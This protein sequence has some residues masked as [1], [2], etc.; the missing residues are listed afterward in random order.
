MHPGLWRAHIL[1]VNP[2]LVQAQAAASQ[3]PHGP[4]IDLPLNQYAAWG[5][6]A[7]WRV[8]LLLSNGTM[9]A[10]GGDQLAFLELHRGNLRVSL[11]EA[12][13]RQ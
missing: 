2:S 13:L 5:G 12:E 7:D 11:E 9:V 1:S 10:I 6:D 3:G 4:S 8:K